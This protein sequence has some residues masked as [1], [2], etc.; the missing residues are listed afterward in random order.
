MSSSYRRLL[1]TSGRMMMKM[2]N[3]RCRTRLSSSGWMRLNSGGR[4]TM[5]ELTNDATVEK[6]IEEYKSF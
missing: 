1:N 3:P 5:V 4:M 6:M 2:M